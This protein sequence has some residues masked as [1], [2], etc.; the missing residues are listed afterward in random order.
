MIMDYALRLINCEIM[1]LTGK[2][3]ACESDGRDCRQMKT[4]LS[5]LLLAEKI[6]RMERDKLLQYGE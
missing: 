4:D 5:G 6:I 2:L 3:A 1:N